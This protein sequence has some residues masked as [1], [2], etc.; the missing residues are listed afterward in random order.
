MM[1]NLTVKQVQKGEWVPIT[2]F[3]PHYNRLTRK[4]KLNATRMVRRQNPMAEIGRF[5]QF[6][7]GKKLKLPYIKLNQQSLI[8]TKPKTTTIPYVTVSQF[9]KENWTILESIIP[10]YLNMTPLQRRRAT[11]DFRLQNPNIPFSYASS[12]VCINPRRSGPIPVVRLPKPQEQLIEKPSTPTWAFVRY[13]T[14]ELDRLETIINGLEMTID[15][16]SNELEKMKEKNSPTASDQPSEGSTRW[17]K[18]WLGLS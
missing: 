2:Q 6:K 5:S 11:R 7:N 1:Q 12:I 10:E 14:A 16:L 18:K 15:R 4:G 9:Y 17:F 13:L 3:V 8:P